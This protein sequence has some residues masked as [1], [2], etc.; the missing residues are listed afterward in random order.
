[1]T[2]PFPVFAIPGHRN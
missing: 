1:M 2:D